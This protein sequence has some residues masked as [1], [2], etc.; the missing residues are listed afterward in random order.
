MHRKACVDL[1]IWRMFY[2]FADDN[3][4]NEYGRA[5]KVFV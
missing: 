2:I 4:Y 1:V 5:N 3:E